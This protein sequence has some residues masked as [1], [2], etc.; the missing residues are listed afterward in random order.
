MLLLGRAVARKQSGTRS[1][2]LETTDRS[3]LF[4]TSDIPDTILGNGLVEAREMEL[5]ICQ[6]SSHAVHCGDIP[7]DRIAKIVANGDTISYERPSQGALRA[8]ALQEDFWAS[9]DQLLEP[10]QKHKKV[11]LFRN[12]HN[13]VPTCPVSAATDAWSGPSL[14]TVAKECRTV[15]ATGPGRT[16]GAMMP[17]TRLSRC[18]GPQRHE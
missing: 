5:T 1:E 10:D 18:R 7:A 2:K 6:T 4:I 11:D 14:D 13:Y 17:H 12:S 15:L 9:A 16:D 8:L 3:L